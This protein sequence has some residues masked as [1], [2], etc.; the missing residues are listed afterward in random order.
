MDDPHSFNIPI[1]FSPPTQ[2]LSVQRLPYPPPSN[3][4]LCLFWQRTFFSPCKST[5]VQAASIPG[6]QTA[7]PTLTPTF[8]RKYYVHTAATAMGHLNRTRRNLRTTHPNP[9]SVPPSP[10]SAIKKPSEVRVHLYSPTLTN[11]SDASGTVL[12]T[13][14]HF[15]ITYNFDANYISAAPLSSYSAASYLKSYLF[16]I[17]L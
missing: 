13:G 5:F 9:Y 4:A 1:P 2:S 16:T 11:Y 17:E 10:P 8:I 3:S 15:L 14:I 6:F 12:D 7:F